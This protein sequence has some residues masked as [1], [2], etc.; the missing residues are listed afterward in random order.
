[1]L[2]SCA[3]LLVF[4]HGL[5]RAWTP[6]TATTPARQRQRQRHSLPR[7]SFDA[8]LF[9]TQQQRPSISTM[10]LSCS[11]VVSRTESAP[12]QEED[13]ENNTSIQQQQTQQRRPALPPLAQPAVQLSDEEYLRRLGVQLEK[14]RLKDLLSPLLSKEVSDS[15]SQEKVDWNDCGPCKAHHIKPVFLLATQCCL[16]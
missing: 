4:R 11:A 8:T 16:R 15:E 10:V 12:I 7:T 5:C 3:I 1:M 14:L 9:T 13:D 6:P 2:V